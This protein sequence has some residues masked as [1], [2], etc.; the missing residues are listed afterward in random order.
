[1]ER[2]GEGWRE[3]ER[4]REGWIVGGR[5]EK[6]DGRTDRQT[7]EG[8]KKQADS[9]RVGWRDEGRVGLGRGG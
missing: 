2:E 7:E 4:E 1:M 5:E 8:R 3:R 6:T 9:L